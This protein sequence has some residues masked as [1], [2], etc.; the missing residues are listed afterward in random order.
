MVWADFDKALYAYEHANPT[1]RITRI[2]FDGDAPEH[3]VGM[4]SECDLSHGKP[5]IRLSSGDIIEI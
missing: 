4:N 5:S 1:H 3:Y 2:F